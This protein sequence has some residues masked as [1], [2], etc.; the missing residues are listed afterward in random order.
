[1]YEFIANLLFKKDCK[2]YIVRKI[3]I[4]NLL[5]KRVNQ[6]HNSDCYTSSYIIVSALVATTISSHLA[7][8]GLNLGHA[9]FS[10]MCGLLSRFYELSSRM[11]MGSLFSPNPLSWVTKERECGF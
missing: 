7:A 11:C 1:M 4:A 2:V 8:Q 3:I 6:C 10:H 5:F 9:T